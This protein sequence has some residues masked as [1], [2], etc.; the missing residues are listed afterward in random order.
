MSVIG[1]IAHIKTIKIDSYKDSCPKLS[2]N[3]SLNEKDTIFPII[4][5]EYSVLRRFIRR[6]K[7]QKVFPCFLFL[8]RMMDGHSGS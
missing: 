1:N 8:I 3:N 4:I 6:L 5:G 2:S 7:N